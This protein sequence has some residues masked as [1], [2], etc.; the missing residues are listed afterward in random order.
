MP[1][2]DNGPLLALTAASSSGVDI[3]FVLS[4]FVLLLPYARGEELGGREYVRRRAARLIPAYGVLLAVAVML[5]AIN[6]GAGSSAR[7]V[8]FAAVITHALFLQHIAYAVGLGVGRGLPAMGVTW[9]LCCEVAFYALVPVIGPAVRRRPALTV[10]IGLAITL[11]WRAF[12]MHVAGAGAL[13]DADGFAPRLATQLPSYAGHFALGMGAAIFATR[14]R[15][16]R[17][18]SR[19]GSA[20]TIAG[21]ASL[22]LAIDVAGRRLLAASGGEAGRFLNALPIAIAAAVLVTGLALGAGRAGAW[23]DNPVAR[24]LGRLSYGVYLFHLA[25]IF[26]LLRV[27]AVRPDGTLRA[28]SALFVE[29]LALTLAAAYLS[30]R[31]IEAPAV[32]WARGK[33]LALKLSRPALA[34]VGGSPG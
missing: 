2:L 22:L 23:A 20:L 13:G 12:V 6:V 17:Y 30:H 33:S 26:V 9:T 5:A 32:R 10:A 28:A 29:T 21:A 16:R 18:A 3:F 25:F 7:G 34:G 14:W 15:G 8:P 1:R 19:I 31:F 4:G 24:T 27:G 11:M